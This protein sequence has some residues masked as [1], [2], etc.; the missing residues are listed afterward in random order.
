LNRRSLRLVRN[1]CEILS[2]L[3]SCGKRL[4][5]SPASGKNETSEANN[6]SIQN[7][8]VV[9]GTFIRSQPLVKL[10]L[11]DILFD[12]VSWL[13]LCTSKEV[14]RSAACRAEALLS[15]VTRSAAGRVEAL[16]L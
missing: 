4:K 9:H 3:Q 10:L 5:R 15:K 16:P 13:L 2:E 12:V 6:S 7:N 11:R 14:T 8:R 1:R